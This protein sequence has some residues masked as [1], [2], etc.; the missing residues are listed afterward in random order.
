MNPLDVIGL[1]DEVKQTN[2]IQQTDVI[3]PMPQT[4]QFS[5]PNPS[6]LDIGAGFAG[7]AQG[8]ADGFKT[9]VKVVAWYTGF[10]LVFVVLLY[11]AISGGTDTAP[12]VTYVKEFRKKGKAS[13]G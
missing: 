7:I 8:V 13:N 5:V 4:V 3:T 11:V 6:P 10:V 9:S 12:V 2:P 1:I